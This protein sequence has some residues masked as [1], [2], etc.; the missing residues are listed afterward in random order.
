[1]NLTKMEVRWATAEFGTIF[2][3]SDAAGVPSIGTMDIAGF[4]AE[5]CRGVPLK[6]AMGL[7]IAIWIVALAPIFVL[8]RFA[9]FAS[10]ATPERERVLDTLLASK[11]YPIRSLVM[12]LKTMGAL[13]YGADPI[14][15]A[16][17]YARVSVPSVADGRPAS[18][19]PKLVALRLKGQAA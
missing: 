19:G 1:M 3:G 14:V 17:M 6:A 8:S 12:I 11:S 7:R 16:R 4:L 13:L 2:P 5:V 18:S 9:T 15:R 10:L